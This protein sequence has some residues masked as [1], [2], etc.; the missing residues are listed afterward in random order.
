MA[1]KRVWPGVIWRIAVTILALLGAATALAANDCRVPEQDLA[2]RLQILEDPGRSLA[3]DQVLAMPERHFQA[4]TRENLL[5]EYSS[6]AFWLR[7]E[8][9]NKDERACLRWLTVGEPRLE[10]VRVYVLQGD[11]WLV[12]R[13]GSAHALK[14]W[15]I[16]ERH[17][18]FPLE[19]PAH[20]STTVLVRVVSSTLLL[21]QPMLWDELVLLQE[22]Q[23][24]SMIDG[25]ALGIVLLVVPF[26]LI[27]GR[28]V[29]SRL[30]VVHAGA[31][32]SYILYTCA[33]N[34]YLIF[35]PQLLPWA[36]LL[37]LLLGGVSL[38]CVLGYLRV[39]LKVR[40]LPDIWGRLFTLFML[41]YVAG[42]LWGL[43]EPEQGRPFAELSMRIALYLLL[44]A[45]LLAG[46]R[47]GLTYNWM[48]WLVPGLYLLQFL[49]RYVLPL[50]HVLPWQSRQNFLSLSS[51]L[52]GVLLLVCTLVIEVSRSRRREKHALTALD[53]QRKAEQE[54]LE[55][56]VALRTG[57]LRESLQARSA[58]MA[59]ISHD[60][61]S[62][63]VSII[64]Y[65]GRSQG[66]SG[67]SG[68]GQKIERNARH[69]LELI[70]EL[71]E[72]SRSEMQPLELIIAPGYLYGFLREI[73]GEA[74]FLADRQ[75]NRF[76]SEIAEDLPLLVR[77]DFR[78][79][80]QVLINLLSNAAKFTHDGTLSLKVSCMSRDEQQVRLQFCISDTGIGIDPSERERLLRPFQRG[81][82]VERYDGSGLGL[83]IV[84]QLLGH[85]A[86]ELE[87]ERLEPCGSR[88]SFQLQLQLAAEEDMDT[89]FI[90]THA[91]QVEGA[92]RRVLLVDDMEQNREWLDDLLSGYGFE[93]ETAEDG[94][95]ALACLRSQPVDLLITDQMMPEMDGW[96]LLQNVREHWPK[97]PV[98]LLSAA[99]ALRPRDT[100]A[101]L[102]FDA[103]LLKPAASG[104]LLACVDALIQRARSNQS[105]SLADDPLQC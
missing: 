100:A 102:D 54:R 94:L 22:R 70:D 85:M 34:G 99:P 104:E 92:G 18:I 90:E 57:Q 87:L 86:S 43:V 59:R 76:E 93:V 98:L 56:M 50:G 95:Y 64:D 5:R 81:N 25:I 55:S 103:A 32:L 84:S 3:A 68:F 73:E 23:W 30:L 42:Q 52:P 72:F 2:P 89:T 101:E 83:S 8:L 51:T 71:L 28:I 16:A 91:V 20:E 24:A 48:V 53:Q 75:N 39:L 1:L 96:E 49:V 7:F 46:W 62:P 63:L 35:L 88:F 67:D 36:Q 74:G 82:D 65:A 6:S 17:P 66:A 10:D 47:R 11:G 13:A 33:V 80:R 12:Q 38:L 4:A 19:L 41:S 31:V 45:T 105:N 61:R 26:S 21:L 40:Q 27:V 44:P 58:L 15:A 97:M 78:R 9:H 69:Q 79:L 37:Q 29:R 60:L 14:D 77:A